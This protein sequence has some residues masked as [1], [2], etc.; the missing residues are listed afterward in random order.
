MVLLLE[1]I[2]LA[3]GVETFPLNLASADVLCERVE[4]ALL[5]VRRGASFI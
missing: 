3:R 4:R 1:R 5:M 2:V